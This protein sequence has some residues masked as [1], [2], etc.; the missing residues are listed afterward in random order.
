MSVRVV[1][2]DD[3]EVRAKEDWAAQILRIPELSGVEVEAL[4]AYEVAECLTVLEERSLRARTPNFSGAPI[5][6]VIDQADIVI[7]DYDLTPDP[8]RLKEQAER[9]QL[10][11]NEL[12]AETAETVA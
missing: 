10:I 8:S 9:N 2:L 6:C 5:E 7:V 1:I 12:R 4:T 11:R 3:D